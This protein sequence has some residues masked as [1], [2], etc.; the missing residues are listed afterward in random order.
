MRKDLL[1]LQDYFKIPM[2]SPSVSVLD[3]IE[4]FDFRCLFYHQN[5]AKVMFEKGS[6]RAQRLLVA[7]ELTHPEKLEELTRQLWLRIWSRVS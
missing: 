7:S 4:H 3:F 1:R 6:L 2:N 5:V